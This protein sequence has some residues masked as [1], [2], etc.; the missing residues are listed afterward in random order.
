MELLPALKL[1][2]GYQRLVVGLPDNSSIIIFRIR[3]VDMVYERFWLRIPAR[4]PA[5][6]TEMFMGFLSLC[7]VKSR[8]VPRITSLP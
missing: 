7:S 2:V 4:I 6:L 1:A 5:I 3:V 8:E